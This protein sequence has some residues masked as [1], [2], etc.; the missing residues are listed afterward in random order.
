MRQAETRPSP[1]SISC[2]SDWLRFH[3]WMQRRSMIDLA[4]DEEQKEDRQKSIESHEA[5]QSKQ[6]VCSRDSMRISSAGT[7]QYIYKPRLTTYFRSQ[8]SSGVGD[9]R[10]RQAQ[11]DHPEQP[12]CFKQLSTEQL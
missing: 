5:K 10:K 7:N 3:I 2:H 6:S 9:V 8:P 12:T 11:H 1:Q 4:M